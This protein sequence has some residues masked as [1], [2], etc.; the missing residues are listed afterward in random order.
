[1]ADRLEHAIRHRPGFASGG[2]TKTERVSVDFVIN[3]Q[4]VI[5]MLDRARNFGSDC[6]GC[7]VKGFD[8]E[9]RLAAAR[10]LM[11]EAPDSPDGRVL[12]YT[13]AECG[14]IGCGAYAVRLSRQD[15]LW[16]W[17]DYAWENGY[18]D[19]RPLM[20]P[21]FEFTD[22]HYRAAILAGSSIG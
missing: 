16:A 19:T 11:Q 14:D 21:T 20:L 13:C 7:S 5:E 8:N 1:M 22:E 12:L 18:E 3:G 15:G 10:L 6:M 17:S 9:D 4:S 2:I